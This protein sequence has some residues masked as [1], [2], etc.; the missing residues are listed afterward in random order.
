MVQ[1][2]Q[3]DDA[4]LTITTKSGKIL[5]GLYMGK[6][7]NSEIVVDEPE[8]N[9]LV[10]CEKP[11]SSIYASKKALEQMPGYEKFMKD[12]VT[13]KQAA[14]CELEAYLYLSSAISTRTIMQKKPNPCV[15]IIPYIIGTMRFTNALCDLGA[16][17]NL[18]PLTIYKKLGMGNPTPTN[19]RLVIADRSVKR[20]I[21]IL[22]D[23]LV[24]VSNFIFPIDFVILDCEVDFKI[25]IILDQPF[26]S[27]ESVLIDL[28]VNELLFRVND[29]VDVARIEQLTIKPLAVVMMNYDSEGMEEYDETFCALSS[30]GSYPYAPKNLDL[31]LVNRPTAPAKP[32]IEEPPI[33]ELKELLGHLRYVF[34]GKGKTLPVTVAVD[35]KEQQVK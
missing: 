9:N 5:F 13:K 29:E 18:M 4:C 27:T 15:V 30:I 8:E 34:L 25:P 6:S 3:T 32:S 2:Q 10:E 31:D 11:D 7:T 22:Y 24:K 19:M 17:I 16:F 26:L 28:R 21:G 35:L 14:S 12:F 20:S 1:S 33:L 23:V